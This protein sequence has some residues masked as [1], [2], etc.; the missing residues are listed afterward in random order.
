MNAPP[1]YFISALPVLLV[2]DHWNFRAKVS[3]R[4]LRKAID[5]T[6]GDEG[7][8]TPRTVSVRPP[9]PLGTE[10]PRTNT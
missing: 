7:R 3:E 4:V 8:N 5:I 10:R 2:I 6:I 1:C 9:A